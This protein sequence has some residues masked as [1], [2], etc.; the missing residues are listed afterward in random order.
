MSGGSG[1]L[2]DS[3]SLKR[4]SRSGSSVNSTSVLENNVQNSQKDISTSDKAQHSSIV[5]SGKEKKTQRQSWKEPNSSIDE[6]EI[7]ETG[8]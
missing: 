2:M 1:G 8:Q 4:A 7:V 3:D 6:M 5:K